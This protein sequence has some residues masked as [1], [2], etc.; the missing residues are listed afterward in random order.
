MKRQLL[1]SRFCR[2][3]YSCSFGNGRMSYSGLIAKNV[4][5][6]LTVRK[7]KFPFFD[8]KHFFVNHRA[9]SRSSVLEAVGRKDRRTNTPL[10]ICTNTEAT[11]RIPDIKLIPS[12]QRRL[13]YERHIFS[14]LLHSLPDS[15]HNAVKDSSHEPPPS[16]LTS[17][18]H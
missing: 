4:S 3:H 7:L 12:F 2:P 17:K 9:D 6:P 18:H 11:K 8:I 15:L 13:C 1:V 14:N 5:S 16:N 10:R